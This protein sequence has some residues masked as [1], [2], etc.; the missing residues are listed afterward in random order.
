MSSGA[1]QADRHLRSFFKGHKITIPQRPI[2]KA[3]DVCRGLRVFEV[4][5]GPKLGLYTYASAGFG[6]GATARQVTVSSISSRQ[7]RTHG[8]LN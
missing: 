2:G 7:P 6:G 8:W 4:A 5:P 3:D 1:N